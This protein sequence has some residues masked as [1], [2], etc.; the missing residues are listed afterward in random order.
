M[1]ARAQ[2]VGAHRRIVEIPPRR[3]ELAL[4]DRQRA[5]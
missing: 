3:T 5:E 2:L 1:R 4:E